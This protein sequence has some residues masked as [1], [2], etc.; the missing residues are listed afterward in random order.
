MKFGF[1]LSTLF[2]SLMTPSYGGTEVGLGDGPSF[3]SKTFNRRHPTS[4]FPFS[5]V[6]M[7]PSRGFSYLLRAQ[8][9]YQC[10]QLPR[11]C[12]YSNLA[13][14]ATDSSRKSIVLISKASDPYLN[15]SIEHWLLQKTPPE[16][17]VLFLYVNRPSVIL[18]RNQNPWVE[19]NISLLAKEGIDLVRRRSGGGTVFHDERNVNYSVICPTSIF[20]RDL[21]AKMV[22]E[23]LHSVAGPHTRVNKRH[24]IVQDMNGEDPNEK[25]P[26][27]GSLRPF[28]IS[29]S[30]YKLTRLRALHHGTCLLGSPNLGSMGRFLKS[31]AKKYIT[32]RGVDSV[33]SEVANVVPPLT[34]QL[35][36]DTVIQQFYQLYGQEEEEIVIPDTPEESLQDSFANIPEILNGYLELKSPEW[37]YGQT[38][39]FTYELRNDIHHFEFSARNGVVT[40][41]KIQLGGDLATKEKLEDEIVGDVLYNTQERSKE[42][43]TEMLYDKEPEKVLNGMYRAT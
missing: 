5:S 38:P 43:W 21:H 1:I 26:Y 33:P 16:S 40:E 9:I 37:I 11:L 24:D 20:D 22:V 25:D 8:T 41:A 35:F 7:A 4:I 14:A 36:M 31:P 34:N 42:P 23:A 10:R 32:A 27:I 12:R 13:N 3:T 18:G 30:A 17:K 15:L 2:L 6:V 19:T 39:Q 28:K 29:G